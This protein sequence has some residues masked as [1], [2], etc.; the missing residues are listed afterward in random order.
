MLAAIYLIA[1][2]AAMMFSLVGQV[3]LA[4]IGVTVM[5]VCWTTAHLLDRLGG[6]LRDLR[7]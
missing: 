3:V 4:L 2:F 6:G 1:L 7:L 5:A